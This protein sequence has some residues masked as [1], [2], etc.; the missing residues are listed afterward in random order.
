MSPPNF[1]LIN[2]RLIY[3]TTLFHNWLARTFG[4]RERSVNMG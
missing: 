2:N 3:T 4:E 1:N